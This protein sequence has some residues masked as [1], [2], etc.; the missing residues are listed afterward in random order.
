[1][2]KNNIFVFILSISVGLLSGCSGSSISSSFDENISVGL[3]ADEYIDVVSQNPVKIK[4][5]DNAAFEITLLD[6]HVIA[7]SSDEYT[8]DNGIISFNDIQFSKNIYLESRGDGYV[9]IQ[10]IN[11]GDKGVLNSNIETDDWVEPGTK[12]ELQITPIHNNK[13]TSWTIGD[14]ETNMMPDNFERNYVF[15]ATQDVTLYANY[16]SGPT[17]KSIHYFG[18]GGFTKSGDSE[19]FYDHTINNHTRINT[20]QGNRMFF[21]DGYLLESWNTK[22]DAS[23]ER[24]GLGSR[25]SMSGD[26]SEI[27]LYAIWS[28][29]TDNSFFEFE[30]HDDYFAVKSCWSNEE[31]ITVPSTYSGI[32][33]TTVLANAFD[34]LG[35]TKLL[36][37]P[38]ITSVEE[39]AINDCSALRELL[40]SNTMKN[41]SDDSLSGTTNIATISINSY[42]PS[43]FSG[44]TYTNIW[45][46]KADLI[47]DA[48]ENTIFLAGN[49]N[50]LYSFSEDVLAENLKVNFIGMG[51]QAAIGIQVEIETLLY[52]RKF[53]ENIISFCPEFSSLSKTVNLSVNFYQAAEKNY[54]LL[55]ILRLGHNGTINF[56]RPL[57]AYKEFVNLSDTSDSY[58]AIY[59][60]GT[61]IGY[62]GFNKIDPPA[63]RHSDDWFASELIF[64]QN[65]YANGGFS[66]IEE[67]E[68][69]M[70]KTRFCFSFCSFNYNSISNPD[71]LYTNYE[72]SISNA[73]DF[74]MISSIKDYGFSG[75][76]F[77]NDNYHLIYDGAIL[78]SRQ[79]ISDLRESAN[80]SNLVV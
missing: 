39:N 21:R 57:D 10:V 79:F 4:K 38:S 72:Q 32:P 27:Q 66:W 15:D 74:E 43:K 50:T 28:K 14:Y 59:S 19:V 29:N 34:G 69:E 64:D 18:N 26:E 22:P 40:F 47:I 71:Y 6:G 9:H 68:E 80:F 51:V 25:I 12:V 77:L 13:F 30:N 24:I 20:A 37:P 63:D 62:H 56:L 45:T 54:D 36:L 2:K 1:M 23:G 49:S 31:T 3:I 65:F 44:T 5:G 48:P 33:V 58:F 67:Y 76:Y 75:Y 46:D 70:T 7:D 52:Y 55:R 60:Y 42:L 16:Y 17:Y 61:D 8:Y 11:D 78:R 35:M 53:K 41:I 73:I